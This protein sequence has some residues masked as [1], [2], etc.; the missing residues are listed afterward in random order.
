RVRLI[1][2]PDIEDYP[3]VG[4]RWEG[5][6]REG[7]RALIS[8]SNASNVT[9][10]GRGYI[11][12]P[13]FNLSQLRDPRGPT[14][15][16]FS[17]CT[18]VTLDGFTTQY[19]RLWS[20]H[21][22]LCRHFVARNLIVR[23]VDLNGDGIDVDSCSDVLIENCSIDTGDDAVALKSGRG[24]AAVRLARP[25]EHVVIKDSSLVS[26]IFAGLAFGTELSGGIRDV[27]VEDCL[28]SGGQNGIFLKSRDGRGGYI[29]D[30]SGRNLLVYNSP[31]FVGI[32]LLDKG[33]KASDPVPGKIAK[34]TEMK[35][36]HFEHIQVKNVRDLV[37]ARDV[38]AERPIEN[39]SFSDIGG[40]CRHAFTLANMTNVVLS[41]INVVGYHGP[42][43]TKTNVQGKGLEVQQ[44]A[45]RK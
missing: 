35:N 40:N 38:P 21:P 39:L 1:G 33:I 5:E 31:T 29:E 24:M 17:E 25:T 34:W 19:Q 4:V 14:L 9:I 11:Y 23:S 42:L 30:V 26:S 36:I 18:N 41:Q 12:G 27:R 16:E 44:Q 8:A 6:F 32:N 28:I 20:I 3:V 15:L 43:V 13:P 37:L 45:I 2:S 7:H 22:E 10:A